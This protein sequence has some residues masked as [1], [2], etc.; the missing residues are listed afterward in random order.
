MI[1]TYDTDELNRLAKTI[2]LK[3][4]IEQAQP[5]SKRM[6]STFYYHC[7]NRPDH[8]ASLAVNAE[9]NYFTCFSCGCKGN[10]LSYM[11]GEEGISFQEASKRILQMSGGAIKQK[12]TA[13]SLSY[14]KKI[15]SKS[16]KPKRTDIDG[17][18]YGDI[19]QYNHFSEE[20]PKEWVDE[21]IKPDVMKLFN[22][23]IDNLTNRIV[24]PVHDNNGRF[25]CAKGRTRYE[26]YKALGIT[27]YINYHKLGGIDFLA[28]LEVTKPEIVK[29]GKIIL[30]EGIKSVMK[31]YGWGYTYCGAAETSSIN[32]AQLK[33][34]IS[35][36]VKEVTFAFD[37]GT[38]IHELDK[39]IAILKR[40]MSVY[41]VNT[42]SDL[43]FDKD[44]PVDRG[45][46]VFEQLINERIRL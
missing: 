44:A 32:D 31:A 33:L 7:N 15:R 30:F 41:T 11:I 13:N 28:G 19:V 29:Q 12:V 9:E 20:T 16:L 2:S 17:R 26:D 6:G 40:F 24:Y 46:A 42:S 21:G 27:K 25:I 23:R 37:K 43:L 3:D 18:E 36:R 8:T 5:Y 4:Y 10:L 34:L 39:K 1:E 14:F 35:L 38:D 22:I 45:K